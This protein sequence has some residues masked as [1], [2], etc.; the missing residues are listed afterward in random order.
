MRPRLLTT[1]YGQVLIATAIGLA[2]GH[3][4]PSAG[5]AMKP[6]ADGFI[7]LVRMIVAPIVFCTVVGGIAGSSGVKAVGKAGILALVYFEIVTT[8][9]LVIGLVVVNVAKPGAGMN[10]DPASLDAG[11]VAQYVA[12]GKGSSGTAL[13]L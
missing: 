3:V 6:L 2:V 7:K 1:L 5:A 8:I 11:V 4:W 12:A 9:A 10:V 13:V